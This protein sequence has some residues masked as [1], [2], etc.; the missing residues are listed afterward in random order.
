MPVCPPAVLASAPA[1]SRT[2]PGLARVGAMPAWEPKYWKRNRKTNVKR[3]PLP[4]RGVR[5]YI[6]PQ[7][8]TTATDES[9]ARFSGKHPPRA[10]ICSC[11]LQLAGMC[12]Q[13]PA[14]SSLIPH[15]KT[16]LF[17]RFRD[18]DLL[19][20]LFRDQPHRSCYVCILAA[21]PPLFCCDS[22]PSRLPGWRER[23]QPQRAPGPIEAGHQ[24]PSSP[25]MASKYFPHCRTPCDGF[26][27]AAARRRPGRGAAV[28]P[29][30]MERQK[31]EAAAP[32]GVTLSHQ[33]PRRPGPGGRSRVDLSCLVP[34]PPCAALCWPLRFSLSICQDALG[35]TWCSSD[36]GR[37]GSS[38]GTKDAIALPCLCR[39]TTTTVRCTTSL[40]LCRQ[41]RPS[42]NI[43]SLSV[44]RPVRK[45]LLFPRAPW[46]RSGE[47]P[48]TER[49]PGPITWNHAPPPFP[50]LAAPSPCNFSTMLAPSSCL[51]S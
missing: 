39:D 35:P 17:L 50:L 22:S 34:R 30:G 47:G 7:S 8:T 25:R 3:R 1:E 41:R 21:A 43:Q 37:P 14:P 2:G 10:Q 44:Y 51:Q 6:D 23:V 15:K 26:L 29:C 49:V 32:F 40:V 13:M 18:L 16:L 28:V 27:Q 24:T 46:Q 20:L 11:T 36:L 48:R 12:P 5:R 4:C 19:V 45:T 42:D 31:K 38:G 33:P 9:L